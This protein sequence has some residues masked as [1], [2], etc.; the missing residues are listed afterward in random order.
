VAGAATVA[1]IV[2]GDVTGNADAWPT[3]PIAV[4]LGLTGLLI[5]R[6][7][8][9]HRVGWS[10]QVAGLLAAVGFAANWWAGEALVRDPGSLPGGAAASWIALWTYPL[11]VWF[12]FAWPLIL[13]PHG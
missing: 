2:T 11:A 12:G 1:T 13:F 6:G 3:G 4:A 7:H 10:L 8:P 5:L 9:A